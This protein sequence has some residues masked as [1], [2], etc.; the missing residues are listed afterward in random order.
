M[1]EILTKLVPAWLAG[2]SMG[3]PDEEGH[4]AWRGFTAEVVSWGRM[5]F[6]QF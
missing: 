4:W 6:S 2:Q 5:D 3:I 1:L